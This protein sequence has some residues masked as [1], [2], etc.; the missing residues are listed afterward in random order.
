MLIDTIKSDLLL[1]RKLNNPVEKNLL[2]TLVGDAERVGK[3]KGNRLPTDDEVQAV[4]K[5]FMKGVEENIKLKDMPIFQEEK[6]ILA[7]YLPKML[8]QE[9]LANIINDLV[10]KH[11][12]KGLVMK[13]LAACYKNM[14]D[15]KIVAGMI[16]SALNK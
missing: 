5:K 6:S 12:N 10:A 11:N 2:T 13:E 7:R 4:V 1:A 3:D 15:G 8:S 9:S 16:D 14:Y